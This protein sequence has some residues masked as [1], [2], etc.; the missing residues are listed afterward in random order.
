[1]VSGLLPL[2]AFRALW[3]AV[4]PCPVRLLFHPLNNIKM[5]KDDFTLTPRLRDFLRIGSTPRSIGLGVKFPISIR[6]R[7][8]FNQTVWI[9]PESDFPFFLGNEVRDIC[10]LATVLGLTC[11]VHPLGDLVI[12]HV[13]DFLIKC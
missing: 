4:A 2:G 8:A 11:S 12:V 1:M 6:C 3:G 10:S 5:A 7:S 9:F 13:D